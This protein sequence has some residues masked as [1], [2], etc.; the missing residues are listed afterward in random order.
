[1]KK[2]LLI[3][4]CLPLLFS[5]VDNKE[6]KEKQE[7]NTQAYWQMTL[8]VM[9]VDLLK[10]LSNNST[11]AD[12]NSAIESATDIKDNNAQ[13]KKGF[14]TLFG[15]EYEKL[16]PSKGMAALFI[17]KLKDKIKITTNNQDVIVE[18]E[19]EVEDAI[20][21]SLNILRSRIDR[22]GLY[23]QSNIQRIQGT[24]R[25]LIELSRIKDSERLRKL[26]QS[27]GNLEFWE[28]YEYTELF[29]S[30]QSVNTYL[31]ETSVIAEE[32]TLTVDS[33]ANSLS[34]EEWAADNP[35]YALLYPNADQT[36]GQLNTGPVVG[37][38]AVKD[39]TALNVYLKDD[40]IR[41]F[42]PRDVKFAY[43][44]K[45]YDASGKF[46]QLVAL[47][48]TNRNG[49]P[50]MEGD[51]VTDANEQINEYSQWEISM[52]MN[53]EGAQKWKKLTKDN[54]GKS[55]AIVLDGYVYS[56]PTVQAE[57][58]GGRSQ[59]TG[60]FTQN[61]AKDLANT[62]KSGKLSAPVRIIIEEAIIESSLVEE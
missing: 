40:A 4:L 26:L 50:A 49:K 53:E 17:S 3:L 7:K 36:T 59:I 54:I 33:T 52:S 27:T 21:R 29:Q 44:V 6:K 25:I 30:L 15:E 8:E 31:R 42:F 16:S 24:A 41:K 18:L 34:S 55:V 60:D 12:F 57:I 45:P 32:E 51:V 37:F 14:L 39:T 43:T 48:I 2:L 9:V 1:M 10:E 47:R 13:N 11:D 19:K 22:F 62:L 58:V 28:T 5:C 23:K 20:S 56:Y 46:V 35:L 38:C 61:E